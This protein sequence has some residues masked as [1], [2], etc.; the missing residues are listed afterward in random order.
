MHIL[1]IRPAPPG[2][3]N[4]RGKKEAYLQSAN[5]N[6]RIISFNTTAAVTGMSRTMINRK[7]ADGTFPV[8]VPLGERK[9]GFVEDE[10]QAW[11][12]DRIAARAAA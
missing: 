7:R 4:A 12:T 3:G 11:I 5:Q 1:D 9:I 8:A 10:V 6:R 2:S